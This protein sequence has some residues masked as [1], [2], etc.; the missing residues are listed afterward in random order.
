ME[1]GST[2]DS[3]G[4][5]LTSTDLTADVT[6]TAAGALKRTART[7]GRTT[8]TAYTPASGLPTSAKVTSP[9]PRPATR[10]PRRPRPPRATCCAACR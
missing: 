7:D 9:P 6:V 2:Y 4:R 3:Y 10:A 1:S 5:K 8:T